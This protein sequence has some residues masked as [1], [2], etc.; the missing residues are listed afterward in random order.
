MHLKRAVKFDRIDSDTFYSLEK[1]ARDKR[2]S[3]FSI[4][5]W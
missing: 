4:N 1:L 2:Y 5:V 3:S